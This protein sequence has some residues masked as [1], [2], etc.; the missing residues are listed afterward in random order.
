MAIEDHK[1]DNINE[2]ELSQ[3]D[4]NLMFKP[5]VPGEGDVANKSAE[6][7]FQNMMTK[8]QATG[9]LLPQDSLEPA[10]LARALMQSPAARKS[11]TS[12]YTG[13]FYDVK[14]SGETPHPF[15]LRIPPLQCK[16]Y[17]RLMRLMN[18]RH[19]DGPGEEVEEDKELP[20]FR[21]LFCLRWRQYPQP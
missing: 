14:M 17:E 9:M 19:Q 4:D 16:N 18:H 13:I 1:P 10:E 12:Q 15:A 6:N 2:G 20:P 3:A 8:L 21:H 5:P 7:I 11:A